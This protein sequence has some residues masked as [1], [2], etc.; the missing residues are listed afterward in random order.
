MK[1]SIWSRAWLVPVVLAMLALLWWGTASAATMLTTQLDFGARGSN[2][3]S[4]QQ[5]LAAD[6]SVYPE[7]LV[8]GY[9]A[10]RTRAAVQRFQCQQGIVCSGSAGTTGY[11]RVGPR[12]L[13]AINA[14]I[15]GGGNTSGDVSAPIMNGIVLLTSTTTATISW[16][17]SEPARGTFYWSATPLLLFESSGG[18]AVSI[19]GQSLGESNLTMTH[20]ISATGLQGS[21]WYYYVLSSVDASGNAQYTWPATFRTA[22]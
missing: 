17:T 3:T 2:V 7:G 1:T 19:G 5:F 4:L 15:A 21:T 18:T 11:G 8:T 16:A 14:A 22:P 12:T 10:P 6:V 13:A 20:S 9:Y